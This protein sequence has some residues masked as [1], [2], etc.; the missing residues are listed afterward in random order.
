MQ[1]KISEIN[2]RSKDILFDDFEDDLK[3]LVSYI[4]NTFLEQ[5]KA[6][7]EADS[8]QVKLV[9]FSRNLINTLASQIE[10]PIKIIKKV[11]LSIL[12]DIMLK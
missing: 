11:H 4:N 2:F 10:D 5:M 1:Q 9:T 8:D 12:P 7:Y 6:F 3:D